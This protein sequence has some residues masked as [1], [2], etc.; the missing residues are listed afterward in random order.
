MVSALQLQLYDCN[1]GS[2]SIEER[3]AATAHAVPAPQNLL[4]RIPT[5]VLICR[6]SALMA[7]YDG[8]F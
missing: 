5:I 8:E 2:R 7:I 6:P 1:V 3:G 4:L